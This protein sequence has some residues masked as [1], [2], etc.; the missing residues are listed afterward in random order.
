MIVGVVPSITSLTGIDTVAESYLL[1]LSV[2]I[3]T[4]FGGIRVAFLTDYVHTSIIMIV[5]VFHYQAHKDGRYRLERRT[6]RPCQAALQSISSR[7]KLQR[8]SPYNDQ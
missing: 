8:L 6:I 3:Y 7:R 1:P 4:D 5:T 2:V